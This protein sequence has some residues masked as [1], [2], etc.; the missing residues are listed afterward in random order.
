[1]RHV[2]DF[3]GYRVSDDGRVWSD[4]T[5]RWLK[6]VPASRG[7]LQVAL[8]RAGVPH[9]RRVHALVAL[10]FSGPR[11]VGMVVRHLNGDM[12]DN[13]AENITYGTSS[14]NQR[15]SVRHGT[16]HWARKTHCP[17]GHPYDEGNTCRTG[18]GR[19]CRKCARDRYR[20]KNPGIKLRK[21]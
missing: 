21:V 5:G 19:K 7:Y 10:C 9:K 20:A 13:R 16:N 6:G 4:K 2:P 1:M 18:G 12:L 14:E 17:Q 11:P 3:P 8:C 15:D